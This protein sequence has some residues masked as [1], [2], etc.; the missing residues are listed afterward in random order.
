M[1]TFTIIV[2]SIVDFY[3]THAYV[4]SNAQ[5]LH[6]SNKTEHVVEL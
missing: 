5:V 1:S 2:L 3:W 6:S 4:I